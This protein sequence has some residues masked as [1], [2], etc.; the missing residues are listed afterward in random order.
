MQ[1]KEAI[2]ALLDRL[3]DDCSFEDVLYH[4]YVLQK[5]EEGAKAEERGL[6]DPHEEVFRE[7]RRKW[8]PDAE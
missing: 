7:L 1:A 2:R 4:V 6:V 8:Q 3:P 5:F